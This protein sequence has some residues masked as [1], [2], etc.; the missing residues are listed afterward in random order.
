MF[1]I[2]MDDRCCRKRLGFSSSTTSSDV[3]ER[4]D[5]GRFTGDGSSLSTAGDADGPGDGDV[6][7][8]NADNGDVTGITAAAGAD[9]ASDGDGGSRDIAGG[10][11]ADASLATGATS[12]STAADTDGSDP[13]P[14]ASGACT[15]DDIARCAQKELAERAAY[16]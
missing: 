5:G 9:G 1:L 16:C 10:G 15:S 3:T 6:V 2:A 13:T 12:A 4:R 11:A 14:P 8:L 7:M